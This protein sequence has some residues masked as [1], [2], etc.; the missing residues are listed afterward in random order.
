MKKIEDFLFSISGYKPRIKEGQFFVNE[1]ILTQ[2]DEAYENKDFE[3]S[4]K[5]W[6]KYAGLNSGVCLKKLAGCYWEGSG[7]EV[8]YKKS[9]N[10]LQKRTIL[11]GR[12]QNYF[13][14]GV[15]YQL[16]GFID[17][18]LY[19]SFFFYT[20]SNHYSDNDSELKSV[21]RDRMN[22]VYKELSQED[23]K[24]ADSLLSAIDAGFGP[25]GMSV[26]VELLETL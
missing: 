6:T 16:G 3:T 15:G 10:L 19:K 20:C 5:I 26:A 25:A 22:E 12:A 18:N 13:N 24:I 1:S 21:A 11:V 4:I 9:F 7:V 8:D 23:I 2:A 14:L 17:K